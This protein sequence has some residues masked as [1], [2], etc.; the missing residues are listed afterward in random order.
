MRRRAGAGVAGLDVRHTP[1]LIVGG[2]PVGLTTSILLS[3]YGIHNT[4][5]ERHTSVFAHPRARLLSRRTMEIF[6][7]LGIEKRLVDLSLPPEWTRHNI[8]TATLSG[9]EIGRVRTLDFETRARPELSPSV[10]LLTSQDRIEPVLRETA[11]GAGHASLHFG[12]SVEELEAGDTGVRAVLAE[13]EGGGREPIRAD[14]VV[15]ADGASSGVRKRLGIELRGVLGLATVVDVH[16]RCD[17]ARYVDHRPAPL[18]WVDPP[19]GPGVFQPIDGGE[20]WRCQIVTRPEGRQADAYT[21]EDCIAWIRA[22]LGDSSAESVRP[23]ILSARPWTMHAA[24]ADRFRAGR[25]FLAG[26]AAH[27]LPPSGGLGMN[28]GIQGV[29]NLAWKLAAV[30]AGEAGEGL[31]DTYEAE[32]RPAAERNAGESLRNSMAV[33]AIN[34]AA[35]SGGDVHQALVNAE[36]YGNFTGLDLGVA[37]QSDAVVADASAPPR[38]GDPAREYV[39]TARPGQRAPHV[40]LRRDGAAISSLDLFAGGFTLLAGSAGQ[41]WV[42]AARELPPAPHVPLRA[43]RIGPGAQV[44]DPAGDFE[45][46]YGLSPEGAV[47]VRPDGHVGWRHAGAP[48]DARAELE[49][50]WQVL[51]LHGG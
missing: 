14:Y 22:A 40:E 35:R 51:R 33:L 44:E 41:A 9:P 2:G 48:A 45:R 31:L 15:A 24:T 7:G 19:E 26:D 28:S 25:I 50:A 11:A 23:Q 29:H 46:I 42:T 38:L 17:L 6:R 32:R 10:P 13:R 34:E 43:L 47:L 5:A 20:I 30:C 27:V 39:A 16:F 21:P 12:V 8:Y 1:V 3:R 37:Y 36:Q 18:F 49:Q 4:L